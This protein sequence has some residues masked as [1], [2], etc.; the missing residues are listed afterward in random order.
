MTSEFRI[1]LDDPGIDGADERAAGEVLRTGRLV[2]GPRVAELESLLAGRT[3]RAHAVCVSSGTA[4]LYLALEGMGVG[5][6]STVV[7]PALT[8]PAPAVAAALLGAEVRLCDVDSRTL[9][10]SPAT[11]EPVLD[12]QVFLHAQLACARVLMIMGVLM[13]V[14]V[15]MIVGMRVTRS[16]AA[17]FDAHSIRSPSRLKSFPAR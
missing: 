15:R 1:R 9:N 4:A 16:I 12:E 11:L 3:G 14:V 8:F 17:A 6:G 10:L 13:V 5:P 7:V 2:C